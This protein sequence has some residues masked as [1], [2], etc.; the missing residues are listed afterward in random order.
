MSLLEKIEN[1]LLEAMRAHDE[2]KRD[3]LR[4]LKSS[5]KNA[6]IEKGQALNEE[7]VV[8]VIRKELK[9]R[10]EA[11]ESY[12]AANKPDEQAQ[13]EQEAKILNEY[14]PSQMSE[15]EVRSFVTNFLKNNPTDASKIGQA[16]GQL[17]GQ[18]KGEA[19]MGLVSKMLREQIAD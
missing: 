6:E 9:R 18:L 14:L 13:E 8:A 12:K 2:L 15:E 16:M 19:D 7:E 1:E 11:I 10:N 4:M 3:T 5:V 17:S